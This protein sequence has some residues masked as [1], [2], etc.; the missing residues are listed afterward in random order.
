MV[1]RSGGARGDAAHAVENAAA[2]EHRFGEHGLA[3][4]GVAHDGKVS[5]FGRLVGFH[6]IN[7]LDS[8]RFSDN[9][10]T[11]SSPLLPA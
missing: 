8:I 5:D 2:N 9:G 6:A 11:S 7:V 10:G 1:I 3:G 4:R